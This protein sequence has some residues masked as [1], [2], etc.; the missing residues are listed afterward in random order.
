MAVLGSSW[1]GNIDELLLLLVGGFAI[2]RRAS[3]ITSLRVKPV[4]NKKQF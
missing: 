4:N 3:I 2:G 1:S